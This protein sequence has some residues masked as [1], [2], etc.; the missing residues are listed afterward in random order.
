MGRRSAE[1]S[2]FSLTRPTI[3]YRREMVGPQQSAP[4]R[5]VARIA[6]FRDR[7]R[8][9]PGGWIA[10]RIAVT[11]VGVAVIL[12]G[13][14]LVPLPGPGWLTVFAGIGILG[15]EYAWAKRL[16]GWVRRLVG[17]WTAWV[18]VQPRWVQMLVGLA[19][20]IFV[21]AVVYGTWLLYR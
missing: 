18:A 11:V 9:R 21:A 7:V 10:W 3:S 8:G 5:G 14:V 15:T 16:L 4:T 13:L 17:R 6:A 2:H 19:G 12:L 1:L 20:L